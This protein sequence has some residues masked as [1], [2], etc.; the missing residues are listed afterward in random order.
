MKNDITPKYYW[1]EKLLYLEPYTF[2]TIFS[3]GTTIQE[4]N[5]RPQ[6]PR[7]EVQTFCYKK[8]RIFNIKANVQ[9][10]LW[11][12]KIRYRKK[13]GLLM[14]LGA[15]M[16]LAISPS[17]SSVKVLACNNG[18]SACSWLPSSESLAKLLRNNGEGLWRLLKGS[19]DERIIECD[20][21]E[22]T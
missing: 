15:V 8:R 19:C 10:M 4:K 3:L 5:Q 17:I 22:G 13:G 7:L 21:M 20:S 12:R 6:A 14:N 2:K 18:S 11:W 1:G 9:S 16:P